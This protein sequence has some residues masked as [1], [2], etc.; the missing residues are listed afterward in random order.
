M[1]SE[2]FEMYI[3]FFSNMTIYTEMT[4]SL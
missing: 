1:T 4:P 2:H 3:V